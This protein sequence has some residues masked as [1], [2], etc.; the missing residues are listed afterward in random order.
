M[1]C[2]I[3]ISCEN[4]NQE[5]SVIVDSWNDIVR[6]VRE[7]LQAL[8]GVRDDMLTL[9]CI[10]ISLPVILFHILKSIHPRHDIRTALSLNLDIA[11]VNPTNKLLP[12][13]FIMP[14][15]SPLGLG[16]AFFTLTK[17]LRNCNT[18]IKTFETFNLHTSKDLQVKLFVQMCGKD[19]RARDT[20]LEIV[21]TW[22]AAEY[23]SCAYTLSLK[24]LDYNLTFPLPHVHRNGENECEVKRNE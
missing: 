7:N 18:L 9:G 16:Q 2:I 1:K 13:Y 8:S 3:L 10:P 24:L 15:Q 6:K 12:D 23:N 5:P 22:P 21:N 17:M 20:Y 19:A 11:L 14:K 4:V